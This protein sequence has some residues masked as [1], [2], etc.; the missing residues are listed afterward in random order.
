MNSFEA[1]RKGSDIDLRGGK[2]VIYARVSSSKQTKVGDGLGSQQTRCREYARYKG[3]NVV[4]TFTDD[5]SG[6]LATRPGMKAMLAFL[7][8]HR[9]KEP[10]TVIIDDISRLARGI[11]AHLQLRAAIGEA[12]GILKSPTIEFGEDSDSILVENMLASVSQHQRQK[13]AEQTVNR[14][15]ARLMN[16]YW[17]FA[18]PIGYRYQRV[19][20]NGNMLVRNEPFASILQEALEG[21]ASGRFDSQVEVKRFLEAHPDY[22][23]DLPNGEIRNQRITDILTRPVYAGYVES[24]KWNVSLRKG[25]HE[26]LISFETF[27]R[28]QTR[29]REGARAPARKDINEDFPLRG[30][31]AC[32]D[33]GK[34]LTACWSKSQTGKKHPYYMCYAKECSSYRKSIARDKIEGEFEV[35]LKSLQPADNLFALAKAMFKDAWNQRLAQA[36]HAA[37]TIKRDINAIDRQ[38]DQLLERIVGAENPTVI[39]AYEAKLA[40]LEKEKLI[41]AEKLENAGKPRHAFDE[42]FE[43]SLRFLSSPWNLWA[44]GQMHLRRIVLR[45]AFAKRITY[46]RNEGFSNPTLS[47]PFNALGG[48]H[49]GKS[50]MAR[51]KGFEPLTPRFVV[52]CSI[53]LSYGC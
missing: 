31:V 3:L 13:N 45:L 28:I 53:Q 23:G 22:P 27:E 4:E 1:N 30:F 37:A 46:T 49:M 15:R 20:G 12:G 40:K 25:H 38:V 43:L 11:E 42:M 26:G 9:G 14:M 34:P 48:I 36:K 5:M 19:S 32:G 39:S 35:I 7:R 50:E 2:A 24:Q 47:S 52:W 51:P 6:S 16:G 17:P 8:K 44:S 21:F 18:C 29:L 41:K 10:V 33:C